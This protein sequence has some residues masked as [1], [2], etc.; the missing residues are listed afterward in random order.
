M[1]TTWL[2][3]TYL[4]QYCAIVTKVALNANSVGQPLKLMA[5]V[6]QPTRMVVVVNGA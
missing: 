5:E 6:N 2:E 1:E 3:N 4:K